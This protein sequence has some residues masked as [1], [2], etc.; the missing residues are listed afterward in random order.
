MCE[1][2]HGLAVATSNQINSVDWPQ[3]C[4][5]NENG[6][7]FN[8]ANGLTAEA[9]SQDNGLNTNNGGWT[10]GGGVRYAYCQETPASGASFAMITDALQTGDPCANSAIG[11][12]VA[13]TTTS[14]CATAM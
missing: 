6:F 1:L 7:W 12:L 10:G 5:V 3:G 11:N 4:F 2:A 13:I 8:G 14:V 9:W